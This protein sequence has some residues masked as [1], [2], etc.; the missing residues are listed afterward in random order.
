MSARG[1]VLLAVLSGALGCA[2]EEGRVYRNNDLMLLT[3]YSA[4]DICSCLFVMGQ[5]EDH[6]E[7]WARANPNL[8]TIQ[9]DRSARTVTVQSMLLFSARARWVM[10]R[11]GCVSE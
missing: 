6:C 8:K 1:L 11:R 2:E 3:A 10:P 7:R 5:T 4:K 9:V